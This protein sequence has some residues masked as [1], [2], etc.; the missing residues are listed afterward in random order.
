MTIAEAGKQTEPTTSQAMTTALQEMLA[1][2]EPLLDRLHWHKI[3]AGSNSY[4]YLQPSQAP[5]PSFRAI[6]AAWDATHGVW[7]PKQESVAILGGELEIDVAILDMYGGQL[8]MGMRA[9]ELK[10][11]TIAIKDK[12]LQ[13]F[14]EG[15]VGVDPA[16]FEGL[17]TRV[18]GSGMDFDMSSGTDRAALTLAKLDE[19][20]EAVLGGVERKSIATNQWLRRKINA[21]IRESSQAQE[22]VD[23]GF[24][25]IMPSYGG[26]PL[27]VIQKE[28]DMSTILDF[29]E[30]PGDGGDDT[31]S[32]YCIRFANGEEPGVFGL[33]GNNGGWEAKAFG[34]QESVPRNLDRF[35]AY[36]GLAAPHPRA[37]ARLHS[38]GK[39]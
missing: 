34:E 30:D 21:L 16:A 28:S 26:V 15:D 11:W 39:I 19:V 35:S 3:P 23:T 36:V 27:I 6:N 37:F 22:T 7:I 8:S 13:T 29:D 12:W 5:T 4:R 1:Q 18:A 10:A 24:G 9:R 38:V 33:M 2:E 20:I 31:A 17:R 14:F 25:R 32:M